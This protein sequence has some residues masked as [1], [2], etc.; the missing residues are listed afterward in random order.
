MMLGS[1]NI[2]NKVNND[3]ILQNLTLIYKSGNAL[4]MRLD[5]INYF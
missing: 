1:S 4:L 5:I 3:N 2:D